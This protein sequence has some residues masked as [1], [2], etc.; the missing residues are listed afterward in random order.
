MENEFENLGIGLKEITELL[1]VPKTT[2]HSWFT[3]NSAIP[4][5]YYGYISGLN[6]YQQQLKEEDLKTI[7]INWESDNRTFLRL[8]KTKEL[9]KLRLDVDKN[10]LALQKLQQKETQL[11]R[12]LHLSN[13]Y[14]QYL[15]VT[16]QQTENLQS[17]CNLLYRRSAFD[18]GLIRLKIQ[19]LEEEKISLSAKIGYWDSIL[20]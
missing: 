1:L 6:I 17:W 3:R 15:S 16:L 13:H 2:F 8:H 14:P 7:Y 10:S 11:L 18:L 12:R 5:V 9:R 20:I 4:S 19:K